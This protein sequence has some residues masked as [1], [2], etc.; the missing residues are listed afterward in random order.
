M[1]EKDKVRNMHHLKISG[2][3]MMK[4]AYK[5]VTSIVF[6]FLLIDQVLAKS[7]TP[8]QVEAERIAEREAKEK[9]QEEKRAAKIA[10]DQEKHQQKIKKREDKEKINDQ[11]R[12]EKISANEAKLAEKQRRKEEKKK[13]QEEVVAAKKEINAEKANLKDLAKKENIED[14]IAKQIAMEEKQM[15]ELKQQKEQFCKDPAAFCVFDSAINSANEMI[16]KLKDQ[17]G[18]LAVTDPKAGQLC[19]KALNRVGKDANHWDEIVA[20][21]APLK[22]AINKKVKNI[23]ELEKAKANA[24][25]RFKDEFAKAIKEERQSLAQAEKD[26]KIKYKELVGVSGKDLKN[27]HQARKHS[28]RLDQRMGQIHELCDEV[29]VSQQQGKAST[30]ASSEEISKGSQ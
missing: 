23:K 13:K 16:Q 1:K 6:S 2:G 26:L 25:D 8:S 20:K 24:A 18:K 27:Y 12:A 4:I 28:A 22:E 29:I 9:K 21:L 19:Q 3:I 14:R 10:D 11:K 30:V 17:K 15:E 5:V 7:K